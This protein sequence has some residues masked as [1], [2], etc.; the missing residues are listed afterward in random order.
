MLL[1]VN[2]Y[3][4]YDVAAEKYSTTNVRAGLK[5][6]RTRS[7][8][9]TR[10]IDKFATIRGKETETKSEILSREKPRRV[11]RFNQS[12]LTVHKT[13][14]NRKWKEE[15]VV[16]NAIQCSCNDVGPMTGYRS[17]TWRLSSVRKLGT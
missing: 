10:L 16:D 8:P 11:T 6:K 1:L 12:R 7:K 5:E 4:M 2:T 3:Y 15:N 14:T 9:R 17:W 13:R